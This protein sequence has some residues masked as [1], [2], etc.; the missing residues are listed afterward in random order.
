MKN[1]ALTM[2]TILILSIFVFGCEDGQ[3]GLMGPGGCDYN[4]MKDPATGLCIPNPA[5]APA[6]DGDKGDTGEDGCSFDEVKDSDGV[7]VHDEAGHDTNHPSD[8]SDG[9]DGCD[10]GTS[11]SEANQ[12]CE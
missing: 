8:G 3:D 2:F 10:S 7:C 12:A 5:W 11:W 4:Q 6:S 1:L 9:H